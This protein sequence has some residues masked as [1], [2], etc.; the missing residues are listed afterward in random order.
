[1]RVLVVGGGGREHAL[2][3]ALARS[4]QRPELLCAPGNA[5]IAREAAALDADAGDPA[6]SPARRSTRASTS[7][8]SGPRR[9]S[10]PGSS[11][12]CAAAGSPCF[13]PV[14]GGRAAG[15]LEGVRQGDDG[16][17]RRADRRPPGRATTVEEGLAA[18]DRYPAVIKADGLAAGKGVV[19]AAD[20]ARGAR[21]ARGD[22]RGAPLRRPAGPGRGAPRGR[23]AV[24]CS[25]C[26]T[27][28]ARC[29]SR[30]R[31]TTSASATA[32]PG[33]TPAGWA[34]S[35]RSPEIGAPSCSR[36][37]SRPS[38]SRSLDEL[39]DRGTPFHGVL[40]AGPDADG[41]RA[42]G[43]R[44]QRPLRRPRD[45]GRAAAAALGPARPA[46]ARDASPAAWPAPSW[47]G[48][49]ARRSRV[50]LASA[51]LPGVARRPAT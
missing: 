13:G 3:R 30:P 47:S 12:R 6:G 46:A 5:G 2:V 50:V 42:A 41:R 31:A 18:I 49:S 21:G 23:R 9:R 33:P 44:V 15:G 32:T 14:R 24:R 43:A 4:P 8:S 22:A 29:R 27:A 28:S 1:M 10:S 19:I 16:G 17:G 39:R 20:E 34:R 37:S 36:R 51:R 45:P 25:R 26:A 11:T 7:W 40:Y 35:R 38:T 48:T